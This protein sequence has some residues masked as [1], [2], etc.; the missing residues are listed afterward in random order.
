MRATF[1]QFQASN[2]PA[3]NQ[4]VLCPFAESAHAT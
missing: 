4:A 1:G 3:M 2:D